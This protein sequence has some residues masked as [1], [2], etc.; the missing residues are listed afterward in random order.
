[1]QVMRISYRTVD[2]HSRSAN[3]SHQSKK[4]FPIQNCKI[5]CAKKTNSKCCKMGSKPI[6]FCMLFVVIIAI[7]W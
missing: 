2:G 4:V 5:L 1:M 7:N 6:V 3:E